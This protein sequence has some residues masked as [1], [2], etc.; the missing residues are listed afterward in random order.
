MV[1]LF[2]F[3]G[4]FAA[5]VLFY[6]LLE[7]LIW[8]WLWLQQLSA[9]LCTDPE[10]SWS[11]GLLY[12]SGISHFAN[13]ELLSQQIILLEQAATVI[14]PDRIL[15]LAFP[16]EPQA[17]QAFRRF[18]L[19]LHLGF[20]NTPLLICSVRNFW[21]AW[22]ASWWPNWYGASVARCIQQQL[23]PATSPRRLVVIGNSAGGALWL[24]AAPHL[25][26]VWPTLQI[27][28]ILCGGVFGES[29][30]FAEVQAFHQLLGNQDPWPRWAT[31]LFPKRHPNGAWRQAEQERRYQT[32]TLGDMA[33]FGPNGYYS[34]K[35]IAQTSALITTL[36]K[37][38]VGSQ[39]DQPVATS[40]NV[41]HV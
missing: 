23:G 12:L 31:L 40:Y 24:N 32:H 4:L 36:L 7:L 37:A 17:A 8:R 34:D 18:D 13:T 19:W 25:R 33:H 6:P 20:K 2:T 11:T 15:T 41:T 29:R 1:W 5:C 21:Q 16:Y 39:V 38:E 28:A 3:I 14:R 35:H 10:Q 30:G 26:Q 9:P 22:L 27:T